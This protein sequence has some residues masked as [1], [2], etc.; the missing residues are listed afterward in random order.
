MVEV[1]DFRQEARGCL[2][3]AEAE[4][5]AELKTILMGMAL[6]WLTLANQSNPS[7]PL[8]PELSDE[9]DDEPLDELE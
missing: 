5:Q 1:L 2:Q 6:G 7:T 3:L 8:Q 4:P 9:T